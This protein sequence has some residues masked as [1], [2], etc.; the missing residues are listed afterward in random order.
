MKEKKFLII[1]FIFIASLSWI[2]YWRLV[3][4]RENLR[5]I[6]PPK[7]EIPQLK[8]FPEEKKE[9]EKEYLTPDKKLKIKYPGNW[10]EGGEE[11]IRVLVPQ[12]EGLPEV[13]L[14]FVAYKVS[15]QNP[16]PSYLVIQEISLTQPQK[17]IEEI[18]KVSDLQIEIF[19]IEKKENEILFEVIYK[20]KEAPF[21][22]R[23]REK[24]ISFP[25]KSYLIGVFTVLENWGNLS[26]DLEFIFNSI[27]IIE[28]NF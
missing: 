19:E 21:S 22:L 26:T 28:D 25:E 10:M 15:L 23:S 11:L 7:F 18:K 13:K 16:I 24:I 6:S 3:R 2:T 8:P 9:K 17:I 4:F 20:K 12:R 5:E 27:E 14:L 1:I